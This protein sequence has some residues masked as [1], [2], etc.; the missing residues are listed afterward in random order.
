ME[1][2][3]AGTNYRESGLVLRPEAA[4]YSQLDLI[5]RRCFLHCKRKLF[6]LKPFYLSGAKTKHPF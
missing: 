5:G 2:L 1:N 4:F 3:K 6:C